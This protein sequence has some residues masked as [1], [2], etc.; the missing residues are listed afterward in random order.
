MEKQVDKLNEK[1]VL[2]SY[3]FKP[4]AVDEKQLATAQQLLEKA[5][6]DESKRDQEIKQNTWMTTKRLPVGMSS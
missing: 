5:S 4:V 3:G 6:R 2:E 1:E